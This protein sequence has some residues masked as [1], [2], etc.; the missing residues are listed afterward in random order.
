MA[1]Q[2]NPTENNP[3]YRIRPTGERWDVL[4]NSSLEPLASFADK[5]SALAYAL[6]LLRAQGHD[7]ILRTRPEFLCSIISR[8]CKSEL[9]G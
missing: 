5:P 4:R 1:K 9:V 2:L 7:S 6:N 3:V 8:S